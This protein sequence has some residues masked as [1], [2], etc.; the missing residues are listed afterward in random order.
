M[1][2]AAAAAEEAVAVVP[3]PPED[4]LIA[5]ILPAEDTRGVLP[6]HRAHIAHRV[7]HLVEV[8]AALLPRLGITDTITAVYIKVDV[9]FQPLFLSLSWQLFLS[10]QFLCLM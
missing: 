4:V 7:A 1:A 10:Y 6:H 8:I 2:A 3:A 9:C 5:A